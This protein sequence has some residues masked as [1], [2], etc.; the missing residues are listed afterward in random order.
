MYNKLK[1]ISFLCIKFVSF[2]I[3]RIQNFIL[4]LQ[5]HL[6]SIKS[7]ILSTHS[8]KYWKTKILESE[9]KLPLKILN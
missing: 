4:F 3:G 9:R 7:K 1:N 8:K 2:M 6:K 5:I